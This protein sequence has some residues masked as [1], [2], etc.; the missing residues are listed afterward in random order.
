MH[1]FIAPVYK[2][3]TLLSLANPT[4][5]MYFNYTTALI[6]GRLLMLLGKDPVEK[7][8]TLFSV[9]F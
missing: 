5:S 7:D 6:N 1:Q 4:I 8:L 3:K 2:S 9:G